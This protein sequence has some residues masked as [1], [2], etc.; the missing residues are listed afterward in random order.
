MF[1]F[2]R[3]FSRI[4]SQGLIKA[5]AV[6]SGLV[7]SII[8]FLVLISD[9]SVHEKAVIKMA[10]GL[11]LIW[12][13]LL[14]WLMYRNRDWIRERVL[15]IPLPWWVKF[16]VFCTLLALF[17]EAV[18]VSMTNLAPIFG[19]EIG[20]AFITASANYLHTV[21]FHSVIVFIPMF[22][23]WTVILHFYRLP[24]NHVFLLFGL[25]GSL[26][27]MSMSPSNILGGFWFFVY[28]LMIY[29]PVYSLPSRESSRSPTWWVYPLAVFAPL[30]SPILL[31]PVTPLLRHLW[32]IMDPVF[33][34]DSS[35]D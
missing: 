21:L 1:D 19:A 12:I 7:I 18:T 27:E 5:I 4:T 31:L 35:W 34:V 3:F 20:E 22:L 32:E 6:Y 30:L 29:L 33:F 15:S 13:I 8:S 11:I 26:A 14:G 23:V 16:P 25:T 2:K 28:G 17:E 24:A 10:W 9:A